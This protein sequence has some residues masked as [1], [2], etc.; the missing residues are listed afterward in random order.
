M[1]CADLAPST[2]LAP[3]GESLVVSNPPWGMR[4]DG[5]ESE[6]AWRGLGTFL[7]RECGGTSVT[8]P[9]PT[10]STKLLT[11]T[12][13][14]ARTPTRTLTHPYCDQAWLLSGSPELT[15]ELRMRAGSKLMLEQA[16]KLTLTKPQ[17]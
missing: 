14:P 11:P 6:E 16:H 12:P 7:R 17:P 9:T 10:Y 3:G 1:D 2:K 5:P 8:L 4:L 15:R 13:T